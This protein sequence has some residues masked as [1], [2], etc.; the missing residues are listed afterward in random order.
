L[1]HDAPAAPATTDDP[2]RRRTIGEAFSPRHNSL[3]VLRLL[4]CITVIVS[5]AVTLGGFG[6]EWIIGDRTTIA[7]PALYGFFCLSGF[8]IAGSATRNRTGRYL[9]QRFLR[10]MPGYWLCIVVTAFVIGALAWIHQTHPASCS[11]VSCYYALGHDGPSSYVYHNFLLGVNQYN[12]GSTP[13]GGPV[14]IFWNNSVWTLLPEVCCYLF[15]AALATL[16]LLHRRHVVAALACGVWLVEIVV[17][18]RGAPN[19]SHAFGPLVLPQYVVF[20][21]ITLGPAFLAGTVLY[22]YRDKLADSGWLALGFVAVFVAGSFLPFFGNGETRFLHYLPGPTS[23]MAPLLAYPLIWLSIHLPP[24]F[25]RIGSRNDYS[26]GVY[27][28]GW[29]VLQILGIWGVQRW[30]YPAYTAVAIAASLALGMFSWHL[31][32]KRALSLKKLDPKSILTLRTRRI[33]VPS[34][35]VAPEGA[36]DGPRG[37]TTAAHPDPGGAT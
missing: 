16:K 31:V 11:I 12:I 32:E 20:G 13:F 30:G 18:W 22:L 24:L 3:N 4:F 15:L 35:A 19:V 2:T 7:V 33:V 26:Y 21:V 23:V 27:I 37:P 9:W 25:Q 10:I 28:Y 36:T 8:L 29:P 1:T 6:S 14:P 17:A 34:A 5:H